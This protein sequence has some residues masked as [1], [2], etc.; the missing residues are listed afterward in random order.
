[1]REMDSN[2]SISQACASCPAGKKIRQGEK[3]EQA[4][5]IV[6]ELRKR[7]AM[8]ITNLQMGYELKQMQN[9]VLHT[10]EEGY[11]FYTQVLS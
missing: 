8:R 7:H 5:E 3:E 9:S 1:M 4:D 11:G 10:H 2:L 6:H